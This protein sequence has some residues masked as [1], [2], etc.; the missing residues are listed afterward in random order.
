MMTPYTLRHDGLSWALAA[1]TPPSDVACFGGRS[2]TMLERVYAPLLESSADL[3][4]SGSMHSS[5]RP[6]R[7]ILVVATT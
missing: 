5:G 4:G 6:T 7:I 3:P 1:R 2:V